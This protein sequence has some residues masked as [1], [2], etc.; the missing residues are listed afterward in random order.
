[1]VQKTALGLCFLYSAEGYLRPFWE[2]F[3]VKVGKK[4]RFDSKVGIPF[5]QEGFPNLVSFLGNKSMKN[6]TEAARDW[7]EVYIYS[8]N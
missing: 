3:K 1:M 4:I 8:W 2:K 5:S 6:K 7:E